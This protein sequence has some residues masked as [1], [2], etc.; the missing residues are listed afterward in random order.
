[1][2][3]SAATVALLSAYAWRKRAI[4]GALPFAVMTATAVPWAVGGAFELAAVEIPDKVFWTQFQR[5]WQLPNVTAALWFA[6]DYTNLNR[7]LTRRTLGLLAVPPAAYLVLAVTNGSH[8]LIW[9]GFSFDGDVHLLSAKGGWAFTDFG[10]TVGMVTA[11]LF[12]WLFIQS[13]L[14]RR[15]VALCLGGH[16]TTRAANLLD[17]ANANPVPPM[18]PTMI[19]V[20]FASVMYAVALFHFRLFDLVPVAYAT[21]IEQMR[22]AMLVLD[23][24]RRIVDLNPAAESILGI[25]RGSARGTD[26]GRVLPPLAGANAVTGAATAPAEITLETGKGRRHYSVHVSPLVDRRQF[27]RGDLVL[28]HDI[29]E[30]KLAHSQLVDTQRALA[31][32]RERDRVARDLHDSL[33][34]VIGF[35][36]MEAQAAR[37]FLSRNQASEAERNLARL[38]AAAQEAH[39]DVRQYILGARAGVANGSFLAS[40]EQCLQGLRQTTGLATKLDAP[41]TLGGHPFNPTVEAQLLYMIQEAL[42]NI[43]KHAA[44]HEVVVRLALVN[45]CVEAIVQDDGV[46]FDPASATNGG[47]TFGLRIM[48]ERAAEVGGTVTMRSTPG[49]GA[50]LVI[51]VPL[52]EAS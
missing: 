48:Q 19:A 24:R 28:L 11:L 6:L 40:L 41:D 31:T 35:L 5:V 13:P 52:R 27:A 30:Q 46:G 36:K 37:S 8:Q 26:V 14:H 43:R 47:Q 39:T 10:L 44:A 49:R 32:L 50:E 20:A 9:S 18:D 51:S 34:Q 33:G 21:V 17:M 3:A 25:P 7:G 29:T 16:L 4:P 42:T 15:P 12:V 1:M 38:V 22:E 45:G 2:V 23:A